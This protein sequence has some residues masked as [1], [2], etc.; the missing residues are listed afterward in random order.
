MRVSRA[1]LLV[2]LSFLGCSPP[3]TFDPEDFRPEREEKVRELLRRG[4]EELRSQDTGSLIRAQAYFELALELRPLDP[5]AL[6]GMG[7]VAFRLS[8]FSSAELF[9]RRAFE[10]NPNYDRA[11]E[12]LAMLQQQFGQLELAES[13]YRR[14]IRVNPLN[15]R[16][17]NNLFVLRKALA[18]GKAE[19]DPTKTEL[20]KAE[21]LFEGPAPLVLDET[22][23]LRRNLSDSQ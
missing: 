14:A 15:Y 16:A 11:L 23:P 19:K 3:Q 6:D 8:R 12:H 18:T 21:V 10:G 17:R 20:L 7:C 2:L 13:L 9:F 1:I 22:L 4:T 5:R